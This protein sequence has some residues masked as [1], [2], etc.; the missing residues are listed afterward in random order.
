MASAMSRTV[1][2][3]IQSEMAECNSRADL[4]DY[5]WMD[6][7]SSAHENDTLRG[8]RINIGLF[9]QSDLPPRC[10]RRWR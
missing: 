9:R 7:L 4:I 10:R 2:V 1:T 8:G 5:G 3:T 6:S